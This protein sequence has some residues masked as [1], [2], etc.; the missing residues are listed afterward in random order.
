LAASD[1]VTPTLLLAVQE[2]LVKKDLCPNKNISDKRNMD[3]TVKSRVFPKKPTVAQLV[4]NSPP[5]MA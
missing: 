5:F 3:A 1:H 4:R 2:L